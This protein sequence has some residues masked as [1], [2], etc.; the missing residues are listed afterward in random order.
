MTTAS[1]SRSHFCVARCIHCW[2]AVI[3]RSKCIGDMIY[4]VMSAAELRVIPGHF[5]D[6]IAVLAI[7]LNRIE[8]Q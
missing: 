5:V 4:F 1:A 6:S 3:R 7:A 8:S 2:C